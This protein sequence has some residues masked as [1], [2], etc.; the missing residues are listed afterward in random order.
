MQGNRWRFLLY[1][2]LIF[3]LV[4]VGYIMCCVGVFGTGALAR[5]MNAEAFLQL[6]SGDEA[7][8]TGDEPA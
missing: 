5:M 8:E 6:T 2:L 4:M 7:P 1:Q 3:V